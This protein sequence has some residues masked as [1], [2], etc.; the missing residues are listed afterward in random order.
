MKKVVCSIQAFPHG[1]AG[2]AINLRNKVWTLVLGANLVLLSHHKKMMKWNW[3]ILYPSKVTL[4]GS[5]KITLHIKPVMSH[6]MV[7]FTDTFTFDTKY[8][9]WWNWWVDTI[10][11]IGIADA[12]TLIL[13]SISI[14]IAGVKT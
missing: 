12:Q 7:L 10:I 9:Y 5:L 14:I 6:T 2:F 4:W 8:Q 13:N 3:N 11:G 1:K